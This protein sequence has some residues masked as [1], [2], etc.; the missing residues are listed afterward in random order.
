[1][2]RT[3]PGLCFQELQAARQVVDS[4][5]SHAQNIVNSVVQ[6]PSVVEETGSEE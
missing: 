4:G 3:T 6:N 5:I 2:S 1:M